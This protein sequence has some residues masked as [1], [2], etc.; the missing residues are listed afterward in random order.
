MCGDA[1]EQSNGTKI[2]QA[3]ALNEGFPQERAMGTERSE[4]T[5]IRKRRGKERQ[6][7]K[8]VN[9]LQHMELIWISIQANDLK[10]KSEIE[11][12]ECYLDSKELSFKKM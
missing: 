5:G 2:V 4:E 3:L 8:L 12:F 7:Q 11:K 9:K 10:K 1:V 6:I